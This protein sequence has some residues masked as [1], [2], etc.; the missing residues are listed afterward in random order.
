MNRKNSIYTIIVCIVLT[1]SVIIYRGLSKPDK[2]KTLGE[3]Y[4]LSQSSKTTEPP[5]TGSPEP[6]KIESSKLDEKGSENPE[7]NTYG[8]DDQTVYFTNP[9]VLYDN[10]DIPLDIYPNQMSRIQSYCNLNFEDEIKGI[11]I[12]EDSVEI[13]NN[14]LKYVCDLNN[15]HYLYVKC[16]LT[17]F[18]FS[19]TDSPKFE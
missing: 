6:S 12:L 15:E 4:N 8:H 7:P 10:K 17:T 9:E 3:V 14:T 18:E 5:T 11:T 19:F 16:D 2:R 13:N 1:I